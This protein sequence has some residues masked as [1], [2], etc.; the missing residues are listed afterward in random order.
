MIV[1]LAVVV[2][3]VGLVFTLA[4]PT[5][6]PTP[7]ATA[8]PAGPVNV[9]VVVALGV[10]DWVAEAAENFNAS[11]QTLDGRPISV[12]VTPMDGLV[13][14]RHFDAQTMDPIP[15]AW[16]P[17]SRWL[18]EL[19]NASYKTIKGRDVFLTDGEYRA[20]PIALSLFAWGIY[21]SRA[22][23]L[24]NEFGA[25]SWPALHDA[26][27]APGGWPDLGGEPGWGYFKLL[28]PSPERNIAG[29]GALISAA[30]EY[31]DRPNID[32]A[33][34]NNPDFQ[35]W[36]SELLGAVQD[37]SSSWGY[38]GESLALFGPSGGEV[39]QLLESDII[40]HMGGAETRWGESLRVFYPRFVTWF[41]YP[42][43]IWIG[44]ET[45]APQ[46]NAALV[47]M[48]YLLTDPVQAQAIQYGLRPVEDVPV[49]AEGSPFVEWQAQG[50]VPIV[51]SA[52]RMRAPD[53]E[54]LQTLL[55]W[56][57][58]NVAE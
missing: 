38:P 2:V 17:D 14:L 46:K 32:V 13:A 12:E 52:T 23:V 43:T 30:G 31:Y 24:E 57:E 39:G 18:V 34:V 9:R 28:V 22:T 40:Q 11:G 51:Q 25:I 47:F 1:G 49:D 54:V 35:R 10:H 45:T 6:P 37:F 16:I 7:P 5:T 19:A 41:D 15:T 53:R 3:G 58:L 8:T 26:A 21:E 20:R 44:P 4:N 56:F 48:N 29:L 42:F 55:R 50:I 36:L 33:D 27:L